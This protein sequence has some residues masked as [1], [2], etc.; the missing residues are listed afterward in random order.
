MARRCRSGG[1]R[2]MFRASGSTSS[3]RSSAERTWDVA[4]DVDG[5]EVMSADGIPQF[6]TYLPFEGHRRRA[7][8]SLARLVGALPAPRHVSLHRQRIHAVTYSPG[9]A[10]PADARERRLAELRELGTGLDSRGRPMAD[11]PNILLVLSD[12]ER[13]HD[14]APLPTSSCP[15]ASGSS[16]TA[17][18]SPSTTPTPRRARRSRATLFTGQYMAEHGVTE[19]STGPH[20]TELPNDA[21]TLGQCCVARATTPRIRASGISRPA[22]LPTS[23]RTGSAT[24]TA[25]TRPS[26]AWPGSG[27][28]YDEPIA[29]QRAALAPR[30]TRRGQQPV[31]PRR[32]PGQPARHHV[33]PAR[34][35]WWAEAR[36]RVRRRAR[37]RLSE[38]RLGPRRQPAAFTETLER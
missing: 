36:R 12:Q 7:R 25:T 30:T 37:Q 11:R 32:R 2:S 28:E 35:T 23:T 1:S 29:G 10:D 8:P 14:S 27:T 3:S 18:N 4:V 22:A 24:G 20:N 5:T 19:N 38:R 21:D 9:P 31:V 6:V 26:G 15:T 17:S 16:T 13:R 33:V 34:P